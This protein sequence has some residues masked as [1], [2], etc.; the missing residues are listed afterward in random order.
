LNLTFSEPLKTIV[1]PPR[2]GA[3]DRFFG[4]SLFQHMLRIERQR[5]E[6]SKRPFL[7][8][9]L[10]LTNL[11][12]G[13]SFNKN[14]EKIKS[15]LTSALRETDIRGWYENDHVVGIIFTE[16]TSLDA[17]SIE[18]VFRKLHERLREKLDDELVDKISITFHVYPE[19]NGHMSIN[20]S[21]NIKL[22]PDLTKKDVGHQFSLTLK[23]R[24]MCW[25][26]LS[27]WSVYPLF[28]CLSHWPSN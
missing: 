6:R 25:V 4:E 10:E 26:V 2:E 3:E 13:P 24:S 21:F 15:A 7:L 8:A 1:A 19:T 5:T 11:A 18:G 14:F 22:Y 9:L 12:S 27:A 16:M 17:V 23:K 20:S 28:F